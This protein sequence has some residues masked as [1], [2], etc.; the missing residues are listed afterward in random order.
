MLPKENES[1]HGF[2][3]MAMVSDEFC[4]REKQ[5]QRNL[6]ERGEGEKIEA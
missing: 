5:R 1:G 6:A 2:D 4:F 3:A